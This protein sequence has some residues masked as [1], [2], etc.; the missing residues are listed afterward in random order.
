[1]KKASPQQLDYALHRMS[2]AIDRL[3]R[4]EAKEEKARAVRWLAAWKAW[5]LAAAA[6]KQDNVDAPNSR[7]PT[8]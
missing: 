1:M 5:H 7:Q 3:I 8:A 2:L 6:V 4:N